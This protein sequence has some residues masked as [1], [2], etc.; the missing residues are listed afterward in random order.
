[1]ASSSLSPSRTLAEKQTGLLA[2][3][4]Q[5]PSCLVAFS[6]GVDSAVAAK[7][8]FLALGDKACAATGVSASLAEGEL[9]A[10]Q[11]L[12]NEIGIRHEVVN[13]AEMADP[14][15]LENPS[16]RCYFCKT[17]LYTQLEPLARKWGFAV[18]A[19]GA[20][21]DDLGDYRPGLQAAEEFAV[22]SPL[23]EAG[24]TKADVRELAQ[25][26]N[27]AC[28]DKPAAPC[29]SSRIAYGVGVTPERLRRIDQAEQFLRGLGLPVARVRYHDGELARIEVPLAELPR[30]A[31]PGVREQLAARF[32]E[33]GFR[34]ITLDLDG[35]RSGSL[36]QLL[37]IS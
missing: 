13:T 2:I 30:L 18:L 15:Y 16:N 29:L 34:F 20:N 6:G 25:A 21:A 35:F 32:R 27:L 26:W 7:A 28:W 10:A 14:R 4:A 24:L 33:L 3:F 37:S 12:A 36:N 17:E 23:A 1:M 22:R 11:K 19:N 9:E 31:A 8:A 5:M